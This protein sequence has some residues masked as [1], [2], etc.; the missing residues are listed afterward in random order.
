M[1]F[2]R[3]TQCKM[4]VIQSVQINYLLLT[5]D[6][7]LIEYTLAAFYVLTISSYKKSFFPL[8]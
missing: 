3:Q 5:R 2:I 6:T 4:L 8:N 1:L 7:S